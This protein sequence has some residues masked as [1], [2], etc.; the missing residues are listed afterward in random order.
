MKSEVWCFFEERYNDCE[1]KVGLSLSWTSKRVTA[2]LIVPFQ[3][4]SYLHPEKFCWNT[5]LLFLCWIFAGS[6]ILKKGGGKG[7]VSEIVIRKCCG[8]LFANNVL[9]NHKIDILQFFPIFP[10]FL[11]KNFFIFISRRCTTSPAFT[12]PDWYCCKRGRSAVYWDDLLHLG[13][14]TGVRCFQGQSIIAW[15]SCE[16]SWP[17][18]DCLLPGRRDQEVHH[19]LF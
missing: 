12:P 11:L 1:K 8:T 13:W 3:L 14:K 4:F 19:L 18:Q 17:Q 6:L 9:Y 10:L 2:H 16:I 15:S 7:N 5:P